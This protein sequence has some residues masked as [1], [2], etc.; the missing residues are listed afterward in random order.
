MAYV[1]PHFIT[2]A[3]AGKDSDLDNDLFVTGDNNLGD[4]EYNPK[5]IEAIDEVGQR[6]RASQA[7]QYSIM[8]N[9]AG[10]F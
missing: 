2:F 10:R 5:Y 3:D 9:L 7:L 1:T 4:N 8:V 6:F